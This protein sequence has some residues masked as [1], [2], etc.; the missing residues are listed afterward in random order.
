MD[1]VD[2]FLDQYAGFPQLGQQRFLMFR[3][4]IFNDHIPMGHGRCDHVRSCL[5]TVRNHRMF[6]AMHM[7]DTFDADHI[8]TGSTDFGAH[9]VQ[10]VG[11]VYDFRLFRRVF[12]GGGTFCK[13]G[14]H[15]NIFR[16]AHAGEIQI[17]VRAVEPI[18][19]YSINKTVILGNFC[20]QGF[21]AF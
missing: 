7:F 17:D 9:L 12:Q 19:G 20:S 14:C 3:Q 16:C 6:G 21:K 8:G 4:H 11:Q 10:V 5:N 2:I 18:R 15:H 1:P 13:A